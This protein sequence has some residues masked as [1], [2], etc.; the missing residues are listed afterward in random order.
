MATIDSFEQKVVMTTSAWFSVS[1]PDSRN[2]LIVS[3][4]DEENFGIIRLIDRQ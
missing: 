2:H 1:S 3:D 4:G